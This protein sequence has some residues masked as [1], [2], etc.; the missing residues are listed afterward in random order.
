MLRRHFVPVC[1]GKIELWKALGLVP[2]PAGLKTQEAC[3]RL[4]CEP[5][6]PRAFIL[7]LEHPPVYTVGRRGAQRGVPAKI[8]GTQVFPIHRG[9]D[10]TY[11]GPGQAVAYV[12]LDLRAAPFNVRQLVC[13]L[14]RA[15]QAACESHG[16][17]G[18]VKEDPAG[19]WAGGK[20]IGA[21]G[22]GVSDWV[23]YHGVAL[24]VQPHLGYFAA[25]RPCGLD[26]QQV[27]SM[28][29]VAGT[30]FEMDEVLDRLGRAVRDK[31]RALYAG[32]VAVKAA[33]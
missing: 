17:A 4:V 33:D 29:A 15:M 3:A 2:Y 32:R 22:L 26:A 25:I 9:G 12:N 5:K 20:K 13:A 6:A 27:S 8:M 30:A 10:I 18:Q 31:L 7:T 11:H 1:R 28:A 24:N 14:L 16:L 19:L 23:T 21:V